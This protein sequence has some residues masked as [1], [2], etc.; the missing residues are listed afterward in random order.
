V[1][2][3]NGID[4]SLIKCLL[5]ECPSQLF[6]LV[7]LF[8]TQFLSIIILVMFRELLILRCKVNIVIG[9]AVCL[10]YFD[11]RVIRAKDAIVVSYARPTREL[12]GV[13]EVAHAFVLGDD[14]TVA[15][16]VALL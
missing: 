7:V 14:R 16:I 6:H 3:C 12:G 2:W 11:Y 13:V 5:L 1:A 10:S 8:F 15:Y 4:E 9:R